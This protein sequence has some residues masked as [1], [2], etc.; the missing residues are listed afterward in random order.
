MESDRRRCPMPSCSLCS[1]RHT[2]TNVHPHVQHTLT[3]ETAGTSGNRSVT[4]EQTVPRLEEIIV[5]R[6][7]CAWKRI[8]WAQVSECSTRVLS[9]GRGS[10][11][12]EKE[13]EAALE[14]KQHLA[15]HVPKPTQDSHTQVQE[16][17]YVSTG[18]Y[19]SIGSVSMGELIWGNSQVRQFIFWGYSFKVSKVIWVQT[20]RVTRARSN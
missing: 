7:G 2:H 12:G 14:E 16:A 5:Y 8:W 19:Q 6:T 17:E 15:E 3:K 1:H 4:A 18:C 9:G 10:G 20:Y 13:A 11:W